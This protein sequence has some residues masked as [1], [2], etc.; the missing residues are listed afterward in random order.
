MIEVGVVSFGLT[1]MPGMPIRLMSKIFSPHS[2]R[3]M[4]V[5]VMIIW[6]VP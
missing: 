6:F 3:F 4:V 1:S 2:N 5:L